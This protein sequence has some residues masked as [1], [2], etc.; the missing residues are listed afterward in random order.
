LSWKSVNA[1]R[2]RRAFPILMFK[3]GIVAEVDSKLV[4]KIEVYSAKV[5]DKE[6]TGFVDG[7][8]VDPDYRRRAIVL[9]S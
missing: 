3:V 8:V 4:G 7:F 6:K 5:S 9:A 2:L 1:C